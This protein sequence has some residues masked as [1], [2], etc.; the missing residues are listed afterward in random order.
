MLMWQRVKNL[1]FVLFYSF[2][3]NVV[4]FE[5]ENHKACAMH[6]INL[7]HRVRNAY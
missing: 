5:I 6:V 1:P 3:A 4:K 7:W 2:I